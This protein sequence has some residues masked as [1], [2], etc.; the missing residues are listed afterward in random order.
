MDKGYD[1]ETIHRQIREDLH[2]NSVIPVRSWNNK[3]ISGRYRQE[4]ARQ[5]NDTIYPRRQLV[6]TKFSVLKRKFNG[7]LKARKFLIQMKEIATKMIVCNIHR[8]LLFL[9]LEVFYRAVF[10]GILF[11]KDL[12]KSS[13]DPLLYTLLFI[14]LL[15][16][17]L[18]GVVI[19]DGFSIGL[20]K[21]RKVQSFTE[22]VHYCVLLIITMIMAIIIY[23]MGVS[24][25]STYYPQFEFILFFSIYLMILYVLPSFFEFFRGRITSFNLSALGLITFIILA[26]CS[27]FFIIYQ[28]HVLNSEILNGKNFINSPDLI[29]PNFMILFLLIAS[30]SF[31]FWGIFGL[32]TKLCKIM[33]TSKRRVFYR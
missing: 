13:D 32:F 10:F 29:V 28:F 24:L 25:F 7:D 3:I 16:V 22:K 27:I 26:I 14:Y 15:L 2:S 23:L 20:K 19:F 4:M 18:Y 9:I 1:S 17:I 21:I 6:E 11:N 30:L 31:F 12:F 5:F 8:F 33:E